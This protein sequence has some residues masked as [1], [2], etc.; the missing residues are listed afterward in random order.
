V[1]AAVLEEDPVTIAVLK[2]PVAAAVR[3]E[4]P[5]APVVL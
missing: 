2:D 3:E 4:D 5:V 1:A